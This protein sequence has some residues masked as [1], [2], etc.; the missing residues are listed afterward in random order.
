MLN[1]SFAVA[2]IFL[3]VPDVVSKTLLIWLMQF[4]TLT[5]LRNYFDFFSADRFGT[6]LPFLVLP[7]VNFFSEIA[8]GKSLM[9]TRR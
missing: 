8:P 6:L 3:P 2:G 9:P 7:A 1:W 5:L 4:I